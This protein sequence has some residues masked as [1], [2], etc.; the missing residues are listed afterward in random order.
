M[1]QITTTKM[2]RPKS[3]RFRV[4]SNGACFCRNT[5]RDDQL[6]THTQLRI[7]VIAAAEYFAVNFRNIGLVRLVDGRD[8]VEAARA[9]RAV[10]QHV[11]GPALGRRRQNVDQVNG[12]ERGR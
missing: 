9:C 6:Y 7:P 1:P 2:Q 4:K 8:D 3:N 12:G 10:D 5:C 11:H